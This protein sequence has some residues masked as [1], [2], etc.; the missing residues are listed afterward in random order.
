MN[1]V[2][3]V[4]GAI[5]ELCAEECLPFLVVPNF[6][7]DGRAVGRCKIC[8]VSLLRKESTKKL[9]TKPVEFRIPDIDA[10]EV[11]ERDERLIADLLDYEGERIFLIRNALQRRNQR[12]QNSA[13]RN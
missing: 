11:E 6:K 4:R 12:R 7:S 9:L 5:L 3:L 13:P 10:S 8:D 2:E 1:G